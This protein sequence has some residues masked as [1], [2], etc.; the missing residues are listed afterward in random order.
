[1]SAPHAERPADITPPAEPRHL[2]ATSIAN[3]SSR[4]LRLP[5]ALAG[6]L[7]EINDRLDRL[8]QL[9]CVIACSPSNCSCKGDAVHAQRVTEHHQHVVHVD[10]IEVLR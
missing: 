3:H 5:P 4:N 10:G 6:I 1:M 8:E 2:D 9:P 7:H